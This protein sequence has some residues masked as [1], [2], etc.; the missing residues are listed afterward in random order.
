MSYR[1]WTYEFT[2]LI[3]QIKPNKGEEE[4]WK[5]DFSEKLKKATE[6]LRFKIPYQV[7]DWKTDANI[8]HTN[9]Y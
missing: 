8:S 7:Y 1:Q 6:N 9:K 4:S 2:T 5:R 3:F